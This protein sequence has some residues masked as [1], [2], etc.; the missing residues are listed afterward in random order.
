MSTP[1]KHTLLVVDDE[2]DVGD[3]VHDLLRREFNVL[4][5]R[6]AEEGLNL[7]RDNEVHIIMTD[8]RMPKVTGVELLKSIRTGHPQAIRMLFTGYTDLD[9]VIAAINQGHIFRFLK[10]PWQP[11]E[12]EDAVRD[13]AA[14]YERLIEQAD[15]LE[16]LR[17]ELAHL[18][19]RITAL[20]MEVE[21]L[22]R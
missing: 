12:L 14:E 5:A 21:R 7:M 2:A 1:K 9:S 16:K 10:K 8:Q 6:S 22:R 18:R 11:E 17:L 15:L 3:S 20:E 13:A 4:K 19:E